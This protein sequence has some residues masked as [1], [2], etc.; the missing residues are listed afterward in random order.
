M[1]YKHG[2]VDDKSQL[3]K[4]L[5]DYDQKHGCEPFQVYT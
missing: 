4:W 5:E 3:Q 1:F 2:G